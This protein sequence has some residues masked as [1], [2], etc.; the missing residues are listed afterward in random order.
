[1]QLSQSIRVVECPEFRELLL[2]ACSEINESDL[3]KRGK[4]HNMIVD[5]GTDYFEVLKKQ[6]GVCLILEKLFRVIFHRFLFSP[7]W[8][9]SAIPRICGRRRIA[10]HSTRSQHTG[11]TKP[12]VVI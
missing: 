3:A 1:M 4:I 2:Y 9:G 7:P 11:F 6:L 5:A 8:A 12:K 10:S